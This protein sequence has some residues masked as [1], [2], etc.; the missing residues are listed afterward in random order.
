MA[1]EN[2]LGNKNLKKVG[3]PVEYTQEQVQEYIKCSRD[4]DRDWETRG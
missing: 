1:I 2:Y 4:P 3:V